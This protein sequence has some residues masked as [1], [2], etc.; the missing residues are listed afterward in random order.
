LVVGHS[1]FTSRA[2]QPEWSTILC[3][4]FVMLQLFKHPASKKMLE[5]KIEKDPADGR[6]FHLG[7][8]KFYGF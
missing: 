6:V 5:L 3:A 4:S 1:T 7:F 8:W 2:P